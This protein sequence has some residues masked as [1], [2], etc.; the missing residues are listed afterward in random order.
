MVQYW[1]I[2]A[3]ALICMQQ[4]NVVYVYKLN[5]LSGTFKDVLCSFCRYTVQR[6][7]KQEGKLIESHSALMLL[8]RQPK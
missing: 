6:C 3:D 4:F 1:A 8:C 7:H 5:I 2:I